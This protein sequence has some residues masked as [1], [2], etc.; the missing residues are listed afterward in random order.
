MLLGA[1]TAS[2]CGQTTPGI[3]LTYSP[4]S[5]PGEVDLWCVNGGQFG[6]LANIIALICFRRWSDSLYGQYWAA[7]PKVFGDHYTIQTYYK[8]IYSFYPRII[9][10]HK[11]CH[12][13]WLFDLPSLHVF[14]ALS[15]EF[16]LSLRRRSYLPLQQ[17][18]TLTKLH[19]NFWQI[20]LWVSLKWMQ[21]VCRFRSS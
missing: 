6:I 12:D 3:F 14:L 13:I 11:I 5:W 8:S 19:L 7:S 4:S 15:A 21:V 2:R 16:L 18:R 20:A 9:H 1:L 17:Q 10:D